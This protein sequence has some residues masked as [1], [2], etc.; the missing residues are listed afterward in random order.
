[1]DLK[2]GTKSSLTKRKLWLDCECG[3]S[4]FITPTRPA[5][6]VCP[7]CEARRYEQLA[8]APAR[9]EPKLP[10]GWEQLSPEQKARVERYIATL[11]AEQL[12]LL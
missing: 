8:L 6:T 12:R 10:A 4:G 5:R 7:H 9:P 3:F 2:P 11:L 1:M